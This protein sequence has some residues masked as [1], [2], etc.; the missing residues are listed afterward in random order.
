[1]VVLLKLADGETF[2]YESASP[3]TRLRTTV[4]AS[5]AVLRGADGR[6]DVVYINPPAGRLR[7]EVEG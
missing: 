6:R 2:T 3:P 5:P 7:P 1:M 4:A